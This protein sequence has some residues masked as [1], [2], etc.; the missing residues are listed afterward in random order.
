MS[1]NA[2]DGLVREPISSYNLYWISISNS[3]F[4]LRKT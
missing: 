2:T 3:F 1:R 4:G